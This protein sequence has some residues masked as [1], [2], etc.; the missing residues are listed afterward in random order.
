MSSCGL[1]SLLLQC[2]FVQRKWLC[3][4]IAHLVLSGLTS[5]FVFSRVNTIKG[6]I[7]DRVL[8]RVAV[9]HLCTLLYSVTLGGPA[10]CTDSPCDQQSRARQAM[11]TV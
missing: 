2:I 6:A 3:H 9:N 8:V 7:C 4:E 1:D 5:L 10:T 11:A